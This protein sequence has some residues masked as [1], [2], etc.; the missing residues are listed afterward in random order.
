MKKEKDWVAAAMCVEDAEQHVPG[1]SVVTL[2]AEA[3]HSLDWATRAV[4][5]FFFW[6]TSAKL[7]DQQRQKESFFGTYFWYFPSES[8]WTLQV[9]QRL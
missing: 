2:V 4:A 3:A 1:S 7:S 8:L 5:N 9:V 6:L